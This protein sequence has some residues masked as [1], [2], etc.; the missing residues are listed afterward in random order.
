MSVTA[1]SAALHRAG[2]L[3]KQAV[4]GVSAAILL[5]LA[6]ADPA[7]AGETLAFVLRALANVAPFLSSA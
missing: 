3:R 4:W 2:L 5:A 1:P 7:Q 6:L